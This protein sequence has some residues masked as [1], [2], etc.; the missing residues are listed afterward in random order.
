MQ[1]SEPRFEP[2]LRWGLGA[3]FPSWLREDCWGLRPEGIFLQLL[4]LH[5]GEPVGSG[6]PAQ[7][8]TS[9][10]ARP[11]ET[12]ASKTLFGLWRPEG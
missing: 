3:E 1:L 7:G 4:L 10:A 8:T 11:M 12:E 9:K 5:E 2:W 6:F